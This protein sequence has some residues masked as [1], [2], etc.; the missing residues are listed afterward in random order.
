[1]LS[2]SQGL[3]ENSKT[4]QMVD[5]YTTIALIF[6]SGSIFFSVVPFIPA[7]PFLPILIS[8]GL[9][10][11]SF[12]KPK[13]SSS[14]FSILVFFAIFW[15]ITG[16][17][18]YTLAKN[19][20]AGMLALYIMV[21]V[22]LFFSGLK[23]PVVVPLASMS[24]ALMITPFYYLSVPMIGVAAFV[25][26]LVGV[27]TL[28]VCFTL[29]L[30]PFLLIENA[31]TLGSAASDKMPVVFAQLSQ[32]QGQLR[33]PLASLNIFATQFPP[34]GY[35]SV[36]AGDVVNVLSS[37][38]VFVIITPLIIF[39]IV[40]IASAELAGATQSIIKKLK[41][42]E[43]VEKRIKWIAPL[44]VSLIMPLV[45][46]LLIVALS[47]PAIGD[48]KAPFVT[49]SM[50]LV[51]MIGTSLILGAALTGREL[52]IQ[53]LERSEF[54]KKKLTALMDELK[55]AC[56]VNQS[57]IS[58]VCGGAP[59]LDLNRE[60]NLINSCE[61][62]IV[63][64]KDHLY[65]ADYLTLTGWISNLEQTKT[66]QTN[67]PEM[68]RI[69]LADELSTMS[70]LI[71][72]YNAT[73]QEVGASST[74][75]EVTANIH[76]MNIDVALEERQR[77]VQNIRK[78]VSELYDRY[79]A[80]TVA[81][82]EL[83][84]LEQMH[85]PVNPSTLLDGDDVIMA[86][87]LICDEYWL[88]FHTR[89]KEEM[90]IQATKLFNM[91]PRF[92]LAVT[93]ASKL[94]FSAIE[95]LL[96]KARP[97]DSA[98][99]LDGLKQLRSIACDEVRAAKIENEKLNSMLSNIAPV[100]AKVM[101]FESVDQARDLQ[102]LYEDVNSSKPTF[103]GSE[104]MI[105]SVQTTLQNY[106]NSKKR[107]TERLII[108]SQYP[109]VKNYISRALQEKGRLPAAKMPFQKNVSLL[110]LRLYARSVQTVVYD[111]ELEEIRN[112]QMQ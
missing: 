57:I 99:V 65:E 101:E 73:L 2:M 35:L 94:Q 10:A 1:M 44:A 54:A 93:D 62:S 77:V 95:E 91:L 39:A 72:T 31:L 61:S 33:P 111:D 85:P 4:R 38:A 15:Q 51:A 12:K 37:N 50:E 71:S 18:V 63:D 26:G 13:W 41:V 25:S 64:M 107:D 110:Y 43:G 19:N 3:Q 14:I 24:A 70:A 11:L 9:A 103:D 89:R 69:K 16:F 48:Y 87:K 40:F 74:F 17:G 23:N 67:L 84:N 108:V 102:N 30:L 97:I 66:D 88:N 60:T 104:R 109:L 7:S 22:P 27:T 46:Y 75:E 96:R 80:A 68:V 28:A 34:P 29:Y 20:I 90:Q 100:A 58:K 56:S 92:E 106:R 42:F 45:F 112:D 105:E 78:T 82:S 79:I 47:Q 36:R 98:E 8:A 59:I 32:L 86:M 76:E 53:F 52:S 5:S 81:Y 49:N 21:F 55:Q 83:N 6:I